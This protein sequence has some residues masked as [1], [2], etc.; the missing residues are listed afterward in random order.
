M[1]TEITNNWPVFTLF[2]SLN[3]RLGGNR[4]SITAAKLYL[5]LRLAIRTIE[6]AWLIGRSH[7][8][9]TWAVSNTIRLLLANL[10]GAVGVMMDR[11]VRVT[12]RLDDL[13][14]LSHNA[15]VCWRSYAIM[16]TH[17]VLPRDL[18]ENKINALVVSSF[19][20]SLFLWCSNN[21]Q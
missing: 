4:V 17:R 10:Y 5:K 11:P 19:D 1:T 7:V 15:P 8:S 18:N 21:D 14:N 20:V 9:K 13:G 6:V 3:R 2:P 12:M 16:C